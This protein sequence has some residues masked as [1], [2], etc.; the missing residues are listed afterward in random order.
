MKRGKVGKGTTF[1]GPIPYIADDYNIKAKL[2]R[3]EIE[4][5]EAKIF[6]VSEGKPWSQMARR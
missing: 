4:Q 5:H 3:K 2:A 6:A 1:E